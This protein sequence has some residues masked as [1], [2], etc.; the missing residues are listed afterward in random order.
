[1]VKYSNKG[2]KIPF[3]IEINEYHFWHIPF[4]GSIQY[5]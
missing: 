2:I 1:M 4:Q 5:F 3:D